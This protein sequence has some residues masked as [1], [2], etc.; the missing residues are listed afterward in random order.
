MCYTH[1]MSKTTIL[2]YLVAVI[3][4]LVVVTLV[5]KVFAQE[6]ASYPPLKP[7]KVKISPYS[8]KAFKD[9]QNYYIFGFSTTDQNVYYWDFF[10]SDWRLYETIGNYVIS[11]STMSLEAI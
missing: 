3:T 1:N 9:G 6:D 10:K 11:S 2:K 5:T 4:I 7:S 8:I